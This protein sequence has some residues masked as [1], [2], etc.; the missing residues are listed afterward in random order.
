M[1]SLIVLAAGQGTRMEGRIKPLFPIDGIPLLERTLGNLHRSCAE[2]ILLVLGH[3][4][5]EV[6]RGIHLK[7][8]PKVRSIVNRA[9]RQ[10]MGS[11]I[12][13]GVRHADSRSR[14]F[15]IALGDEPGIRASVVDALAQA[16]LATGKGIVVPTFR[17]SR[18]HPVLFG[19][20]Y[21]RNLVRLRGRWGARRLITCHNADVEEI[22]VSSPGIISDVD[23]SQ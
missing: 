14:A 15:I 23:T 16:H 3:R 7:R 4:A 20:Q 11:S 19:S 22:P 2:E 1:I 8:F 6:E 13:C 12:R 21:R 9:Y 5:A 18:G 10:G 17:G